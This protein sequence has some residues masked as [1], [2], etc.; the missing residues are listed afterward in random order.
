MCL[1]NMDAPAAIK[2]KSGKF[3]KSY[4][5][6]RPLLGVCD[7]SEVWKTLKWTYSP[8]LATINSC[9][10]QLNRTRYRTTD[11]EATNVHTNFQWNTVCWNMIKKV[12]QTDGQADK[13]SSVI[14]HTTNSA[15]KSE[16]D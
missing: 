12:W 7:V 5:L 9:K 2:S 1:W 4:I 14:H 13:W 10:N 15:S 11:T 3:S 6:T 16:G 8:S